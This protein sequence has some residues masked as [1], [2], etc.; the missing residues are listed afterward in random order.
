MAVALDYGHELWV[1]SYIITGQGKV[2]YDLRHVVSDD[3]SSVIV[4]P[5]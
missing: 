5:P 4:T 3:F 2:H 1:G